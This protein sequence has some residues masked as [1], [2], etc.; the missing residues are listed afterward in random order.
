M[1]VTGAPGGGAS[2][3][4]RPGAA[5][6]DGHALVVG[7]ADYR[8]V[9][10]LGPAVV[11]DATDVH[12]LLADPTRGG[13]PP[14]NCTLLVDAQATGAALRAALGRLA[15]DAGP[16]AS[17]VVYYSGH[18]G[19]IDAGPGAGE[20]LLPVDCDASSPAA[21]AASSL[22]GSELADLL[23]AV[24]ARKRLVLF[25]C[26]HAGG[27]GL[28]KAVGAPPLDPGL[29]EAYYEALAGGRGTAVLASSRATEV[30]WVLPGERNSLFTAHL[31][32][33]LGGGAPSEDGLVR[34][35]DVF[36][37]VQPRVTA[38]HPGQHPVFK[39][40]LEENFPVAL[41]LGGHKGA[42]PADAQGWRYDAY[43]SYV[44][45]GEDAAWVWETLLPR[46][47]QA[48]LRL[49]VSGE[50]E[51]PGVDRVVGIERGIRQSKRTLVVLSPGYLSEG[52][53]HF[54]SVLAQTMGIQEGSYRLL[55][56]VRAPVPPADLPAR[57]SMLAT[58]DLSVPARF[59]RQMARLV[60]ALAGPLPARG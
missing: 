38:G 35:F 23:G 51:E 21:L 34:V 43:V 5:S 48:G 7:I 42:A 2:P 60:G 20:Y 15:A 4:G 44:D 58:V 25:D 22:S 55:P 3:D 39:A 9:A 1:A 40:D 59:E 57:L 46:L 32:A 56:V 6:I 10:K 33:G 8:G 50:V 37:Y 41:R 14:A 26:C 17:V 49:A 18:G 54:E 19:R 16:E 27:I 53:A 11:H 36:E 29:P 30:S 31:L 52:F 28:P 12:A 47:E 24:P 13:L 45:R